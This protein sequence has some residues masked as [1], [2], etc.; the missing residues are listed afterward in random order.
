[1]K[2][3]LFGV[4]VLIIGV[5]IGMRVMHQY[6]ECGSGKPVFRGADFFEQYTAD[7]SVPTQ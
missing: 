6:G 7:A 3:G 1:M 2:V 4:V 5:V